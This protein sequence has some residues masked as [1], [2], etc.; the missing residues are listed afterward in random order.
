MGCKGAC[1]SCDCHYQL[2][3]DAVDSLSEIIA[4]LNKYRETLP[5]YERGQ[6]TKHVHGV[7]KAVSILNRARNI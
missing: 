2:M 3:W 6:M 4:G 1:H 7:T 5:L